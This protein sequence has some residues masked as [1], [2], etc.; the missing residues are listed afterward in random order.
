VKPAALRKKRRGSRVSQN[1][2]ARLSSRNAHDRP[3]RDDIAALQFSPMQ[4]ALSACN[5]DVAMR[6]WREWEG[7]EIHVE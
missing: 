3:V 2:R 4:H 1:G 6:S 5:V 7:L